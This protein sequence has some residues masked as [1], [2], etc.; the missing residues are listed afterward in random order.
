MENENSRMNKTRGVTRVRWVLWAGFVAVLLAVAVALGMWF[1]A[2]NAPIKL[3][4]AET[5]TLHR[6]ETLHHLSL[7][8]QKRGIL[9]HWWTFDLLGRLLGMAR[10]LQ[11]GQYRLTPG[12][13]Q[14]RLLRHLV[15]GRVILYRFTIVPG[16]TF[17]ELRAAL[18]ADPE[19]RKPAQQPVSASWVMQAVGHPAE[20]PEGVFAPET[21]FFPQKTP[22]SSLLLRAYHRM[23]DFLGRAWIHR[24]RTPVLKTPYQALILASLIEKES[25]YRKERPEIAGVFIRRLLLGMPLESDPTVIYALGPHFSGPLTAR[26]MTVSSPWNTYRHHGLPPTPIC[27][28]SRNALRAALHPKIGRNLYFVA[29]GNG[30]HIFARTLSQQDRHIARYLLRKKGKKP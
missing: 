29:M 16:E 22:V 23:A 21:Y 13:S 17:D 18:I 8:L 11:A 1:R 5:V 28:P 15:A 3:A 26:D 24:E 4:Q 2:V 25:A 6:G 27:Y 12:M 30:R 14:V 19:L 10:K 9:S 20:S 7:R